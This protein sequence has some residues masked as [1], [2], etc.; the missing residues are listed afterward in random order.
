MYSYNQQSINDRIDSQIAQLQQM[1]EQFKNNQPTNINQTF[2][3]APTNN[4]KIKYVG[5]LSHLIHLFYILLDHYSFYY[6]LLLQLLMVLLH[7]NHLS[8]LLLYFAYIFPF[9]T[10]F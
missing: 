10:L 5:E 9:L 6:L 8:L 1:K 3:L 2:Q 7:I 4:A